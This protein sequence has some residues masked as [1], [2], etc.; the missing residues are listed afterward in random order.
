MAKKPR[1]KKK[2]S[3]NLIDY[4]SYD[5]IEDA[6]YF[7]DSLLFINNYDLM[8]LDDFEKTSL[9]YYLDLV[10]NQLINSEEYK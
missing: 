1:P 3:L 4:N 7:N 9:N 5:L 2:K 6:I 10:Y 8:L